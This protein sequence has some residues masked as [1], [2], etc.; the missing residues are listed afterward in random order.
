MRWVPSYSPSLIL[1]SPW[2][3]R[4]HQQSQFQKR[5]SQDSSPRYLETAFCLWLLSDS[6]ISLII[7]Y[8]VPTLPIILL[9][10]SSWFLNNVGKI[11]ESYEKETLDWKLL[12]SH[13]WWQ[14]ICKIFKKLETFLWIQSQSM[15]LMVFFGGERLPAFFSGKLLTKQSWICYKMKYGSFLLCSPAALMSYLVEICD[16]FWHSVA[17]Q[18]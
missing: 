12:F 1:L 9:P 15:L 10:R 18:S 14:N 8:S 16:W 6:L 2:P 13:V 4:V 11:V 5:G 7:Q 3:R 17:Y